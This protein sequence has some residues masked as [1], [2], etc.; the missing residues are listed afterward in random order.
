MALAL[1]LVIKAG[2]RLHGALKLVVA[3]L[4]HTE[5]AGRSHLTAPGHPCE[6]T[7]DSVVPQDAQ[8]LNSQLH[9]NGK[10]GLVQAMDLDSLQVSVIKNH[11]T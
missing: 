11:F 5:G 8:V 4:D 7:G 9:F 6:S 10:E 2:S 3:S 1:K